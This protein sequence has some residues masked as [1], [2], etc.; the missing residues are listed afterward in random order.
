MNSNTPYEDDINYNNDKVASFYKVSLCQ[1]MEAMAEMNGLLM[2]YEVTRMYEQI[3]LPERATV[4]SAGYD[5]RTP[6]SFELA[7]GE[8][9][10]IPTGIRCTMINKYFLAVFPRS[11]I[12]MKKNISLANTV[13]I[14][15]ADYYFADNEG[16]IVLMLKNNNKK[17]WFKKKN[18]MNTW[19]VKAG[20]RI[21]Q[22][23]FLPYGIT[24]DDKANTER[25]GGMGSTG[26]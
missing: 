22:G 11:S 4:C 1:W 5:I 23:I 9:I 14:I 17:S 3:K 10:K 8:S 2:T 25:K 18:K 21:C 7:P 19:K 12:S 16:H 13:G 20:E 15:D 26:K 6:F 24:Y